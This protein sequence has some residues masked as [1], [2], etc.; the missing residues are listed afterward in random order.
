MVS[1]KK[2][3]DVNNSA[4]IY[5]LAVLVITVSLVIPGHA[6]CQM[7]GNEVSA[8][9]ATDLINQAD[10]IFRSREYDK[11][12]D[13]YMKAME[14]A[15]EEGENSELTECYSQIARTYGITGKNEEGRPW[16]AKA[17]DIATPDEPLGWSR[18]LGVRGRFEWQDEKD[19]E[20][21]VATFKEMYDYCSDKELHDRAIDAAHMV[22]IVGTP[23]QQVEW[24]LKGI[25]EAEVGNVTG[26]LGPLWNNLGV[27][28]EDQKRYDDALNAYLKARNYHWQYGDET[29]KMIA[30]WAVGHAYRLDGKYE[31]A[32]KWLRPVLA[33]CERIDNTEFIGWS[34]K[35]LGE[36]DI[37]NEDFKSALGHFTIAEEKLKA[38]NMPEWD[39]D[40][41][42][43]IAGQLEELKAKVK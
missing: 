10:S 41:Y 36:I 30:D 37:A 28:Y 35:E 21:A 13:V 7:T 17:A 27:T 6:T 43:K 26:W 38:V 33:W 40:G 12:R 34:H 20:K 39:P 8:M 18:Y 25:K 15:K 1:I 22:G 32:G 31:E 4:R 29:A 2:G 9:Q 11:S 23:E 16:L 5:T 42:K 3:A 19:N 14:K 24:G